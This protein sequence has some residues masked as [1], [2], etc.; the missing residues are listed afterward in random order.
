MG[1]TRLKTAD[2]DLFA[3]PPSD[4]GASQDA[5][6]GPDT[7]FGD[8]PPG[9]PPH[10]RG[11][12]KQDTP[13]S[14]PKKQNTPKSAP[15]SLDAPKPDTLFGDRPPGAPPHP[16][17]A[18]KKQDA[19]KSAPKPESPKPESP[20]P[21]TLFGDRPPGAPPHPKGA[22]K[23][24]DA[25]KPESPKADTL[26][27]DR[28]PGAPP[29]P[30]GKKPAEKPAE[31]PKGDSLFEDRPPGA[32][33]HPRGPQKPAEAP[34]APA[35]P[36]AP[37]A[38]TP[39]PVAPPKA[40]TPAPPVA[41]APPKAPTRKE[42][43]APIAPQAPGQPEPATGDMRKMREFRE[44]VKQRYEG[45]KKE[46]RHPEPK[47]NRREFVKFWT[48][49]RYRPFVDQ[50]KREFA[51]WQ[52]EAEALK[53]RLKPDERIR[54]LDGLRV[55][56]VIGSRYGAPFKILSFTPKGVKA[57][58]VSSINGLPIDEK[59]IKKFSL[60]RMENDRFRLQKPIKRKTP[61]PTDVD[62]FLSI[63]T[64]PPPSV[65]NQDQ[66]RKWLE[67]KLIS[68]NRSPYHALNEAEGP[69][70]QK[71]FKQDV[72]RI[73]ENRGIGTDWEW[74]PPKRAEIGDVIK[75][76]F[77][78][79]D[80]DF[81]YRAGRP[82][83]VLGQEKDGIR[84]R[85]VRDDGRFVDWIDSRLF[86]MLA[87]K[88]ERAKRIPAITRP[89]VS[90]MEA[91]GFADE[92]FK[93]PPKRVQNA[94]AYRE[95]LEEG[96]RTHK[97]S[98][99]EGL[100]KD[101]TEHEEAMAKQIKK[102]LADRNVGPDWARASIQLIKFPSKP[103][104]EKEEKALLDVALKGQKKGGDRG[105]G[106]GVND[107]VRRKMEHGGREE[108]FVFKSKYGEPGQPGSN[109]RTQLSNK[110][111]TPSGQMHNREAAAYQFDR[112]LGDGVIVPVT[113]TAGE[114]V[115]GLGAYQAFVPN[116]KTVHQAHSELKH[117]SNEDLLRNPDVGRLLLL[118]V[119]MGHQD[120]HYGN[121]AFSWSDPKGPKTAENL[122]IH[123]ID[124]GYAFAEKKAGQAPH[125]WD[126]RDDW[127]ATG[128]RER[129]QL[130][131]QFFEEIPDQLLEKIKDV[132]TKDLTKALGGV[133][134][135]SK[136]AIESMAVRLAVMKA[137]PELLGRMMESD[138]S[139]GAQ[140]R[141]QYQ[142]THSPGELLK[143]AGLPESTLDDI[144]R[145]VVAGLKGS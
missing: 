136:S 83:R 93:K 23:K 24:Q 90:Y 129:G 28:P 35:P 69:E 127:H 128:G 61:T 49:M 80:G 42:P 139:K 14:A 122:R 130:V 62:R 115:A 3:P 144:K 111:G 12:K 32:P 132:T 58:R 26:F 31:A 114:G 138:G 60:R 86:D 143:Q 121:M 50:I 88:R 126:I 91:E 74:T 17:G 47:P 76:P 135:T 18:P 105:L 71:Q 29:H 48:G 70:L 133:G 110:T 10:P 40:P 102:I 108:E 51:Q 55:G 59:A 137:D 145:E 37:K 107:P 67:E 38:P 66:Y 104:W 73:L 33:P 54:S 84:A 1:T 81:F 124:N 39:A 87:F 2:F 45:G 119:L 13:K 82:Y 134:L 118:D 112:L 85:A 113:A 9:A 116:L 72:D 56:D 57:V 141:F 15:K 11:P 142:S 21:D 30:R 101:E 96:F 4:G 16:K 75:H 123:G 103:D 20:K 78:L 117:L 63:H 89:D 92:N 46:V 53:P 109:Y 43:D 65:K 5:P 120:R 52:Q 95:W 25:P 44:F 131:K 99:Y 34:K 97:K 19:P 22:P 6:E 41:P 98:P 79:E 125:N 36:P 94:K 7:L 106:G 100:A 68:E 140:A 64:D 8:R 77:Q 27:G